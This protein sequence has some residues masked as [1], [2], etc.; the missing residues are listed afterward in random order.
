LKA[1]GPLGRVHPQPAPWPPTPPPKPTYTGF[2]G[3]SMLITAFFSFVFGV[4]LVIGSIIFYQKRQQ[5]RQMAYQVF[6]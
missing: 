5:L 2:S 3:S 4:A 1:S 6:E